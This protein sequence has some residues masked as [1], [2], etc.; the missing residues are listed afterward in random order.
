LPTRRAAPTR[1]PTTRFDLVTA[2]F[3]QLF[4]DIN[5]SV[6]SSIPASADHGQ[7]LASTD[8]LFRSLDM[9]RVTGAG[10]QSVADQANQHHERGDPA[11][12]AGGLAGAIKSSQQS[13]TLRQLNNR[14]SPRHLSPES[15]LQLE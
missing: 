15:L 7:T 5:Y 12:N 13:K 14:S 11:V 8:S 2:F 3:W 1:R 6:R 9:R 10:S 4:V